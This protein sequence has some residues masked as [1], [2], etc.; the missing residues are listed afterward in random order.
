MADEAATRTEEPT[1]KRREDAL[2]EG[3]VPQSV[4][5]T[6]AAVLMAALLVMLQRGGDAIAVLRAMM[7]RSLL[8]AS[9]NDLAP[10]QVAEVLRG[11]VSDSVALVAPVLAATAVVGLAVTVAQIGLRIVPKRLVPDLAKISPASGL[12]R[13]V[14]KRGG[15]ELLK[16][17]LKI[18]LV[19]WVSWKLI[20][21]AEPRLVALGASPPREILSMA[22][23]ELQRVVAWVVTVLALLAALDYV[24]Q[25]RQH[26]LEL[27]MTRAE[28]KD[29]RRQSEGDPH[30]KQRVRRV[31]QQIAK[32]RM[33]VEVPTADVVVTNPVHLA[34]ALRYVA[35]QAGAPIVV[36]KGAEHVAE[37]IKE[38][39][40]HHGVPIVERRA[41]AR[42][43]F[44]T[45][46]IGG[47][48]PATLYRAV[49]EIL[50]YI[51]AL[52]A[53]RAG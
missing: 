15:V 52:Q 6:S 10:G 36:A 11:M 17:V 22:G 2:A 1:A 4:E 31:Y 5:V 32:R 48:I 44:R 43:L 25:R 13:I 23:N 45:V 8:V 40:R 41:L 3:R 27:R 33:L 9:A 30:I 51:Y 20:T 46:P 49:A 50:A 53:R 24:W 39:A 34:V 29:E 38:I 19:G 7:R 47:E 16:A 28:V 14:S 35:G 18:L 12:Q 26:Y 37:R 42:A 21:A